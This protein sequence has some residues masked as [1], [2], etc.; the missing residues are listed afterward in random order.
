MLERDEHVVVD[1]RSL[2]AALDLG[3][4]GTRATEQHEGLV[5]Q[6]TAQVQE[7]AAALPR[8]A[9]ARASASDEIFG[10][11]RS[12]RDS[13]RTTSPSSPSLEEAANGEEVA[14]P[15]AVLEDREQPAGAAG[16]LHELASLGGGDRERLV[17]DHVYPG[18]DRGAGHRHVLAVGGG[19]DGDV[20]L[21]EHRVTSATTRTPG[22]SRSASSRRSGFRVTTAATR[23]PGVAATSGAWNTA[24]ARPYPTIPTRRSAGMLTLDLVD[25]VGDRVDDPRRRGTGSA[26]P[27]ARVVTPVSTRIVSRPASRPATMS[28][29]I[30]SPI[31]AVVSEWASIAFSAERIISGFG[32]PT[33]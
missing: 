29:S 28:V 3:V 31:I 23:S 25:Q 18:V 6:V 32:L 5:D 24:P 11:Q 10:R 30:R 7:Q 9:A 1:R 4:H 13:K 33:K 15:A 2:A 8:V 14:V 21:L 17:H 26:R 20:D 12:K 27:S 19:D 16:L 22:W